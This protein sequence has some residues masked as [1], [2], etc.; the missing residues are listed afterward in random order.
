MPLVVDASQMTSSQ[1]LD[2]ARQFGHESAFVVPPSSESADW[3]FRFFVPCHEMEMC[4]HA[5][6]G[7]LWAMRQLGLWE[8]PTARIETLSGPVDALWDEP[9]QQVWVSQPPVQVH[10][11]SD[12]HRQR[13]AD[14]LRLPPNM[15]Y[16][17]MINAATSRIK[18]LVELPTADF[19]HGLQPDFSAMEGLCKE[20]GST[21][22]YPFYLD[23]TRVTGTT[24]FARQFPRASGYAEDA[25]TGI[26]AAAL[27]GYL[28]NVGVVPAGSPDAPA[29]CTVRQGDA[30]GCPSAIVIR[31]RFNPDGHIQGCWLSGRVEWSVL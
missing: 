20:I 25:A 2:I 5:T 13:V 1:M 16:V 10:E 14:V 28:V 18:T 31:G 6:V 27:W 24:V 23:E 17:T 3:R 22:L 30:M 8:N 19:L 11:L 4:G 29:A 9:A 7:T 21:G 26:A 12:H 15:N